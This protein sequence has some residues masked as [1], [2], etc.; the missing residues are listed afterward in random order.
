M[1]NA[2]RA[3]R[4][5]A[6]ATVDPVALFHQGRFEPALARIEEIRAAGAADAA[7]LNLAGACAHALGRLDQ[8]ELYWQTALTHDPAD[9]ALWNNLGILF[10]GQNRAAEAQS[11]YRR[12]LEL[13]PDG[14]DAHYNLGLLLQQAGEVEAAAGHYRRV[15]M[16]QP[17][18]ADAHNN[19]GALHRLRGQWQLAAACFAQAV[20]LRPGYA[21]AHSNLGLALA[22]LGR[23]A[24]GETAL[25]RALELQPGAVAAH[26]NLGL[27]LEA[28]KRP[29]E[30][31]HHFALSVAQD[32]PDAQA[33]LHSASQM[34]RLGR[35]D[36]AEAAYRSALELQPQRAD[37]H[38]NLAV[39]LAQR[40][41]DHAAE[42]GYRQAL[43]LAPDYAD[44]WHN[45]GLLY[46][47]QRRHA[48]A[49][50]A[51]LRFL[52]L[53]A[54]DPD[55][56]NSL[57]NVYQRMLRPQD[58]ERAY[59]RALA[60]RPGSAKTL[61]NLAALLQQECRSE[62]AEQ[63]YRAA[64]AADPEYPEARWNLGFLLLAQGRLAE[65]WPWMEARHDPRLAR[66]IATRPPL[67][68]AQWHGEP[69][70]GLAIV[71]WPEQGLGD[72]LQFVRYLPLLKAAGARRV[73]LV[74]Q[75]ALVALLRG[76]AGADQVVA[77][78]AAPG[79]LD[80]HDVW[81][82]MLSLPMHF[83]TT[84][85]TI[86]AHLPY[87]AP[88]VARL[89][90]WRSRLEAGLPHGARRV[91]LV[92]RGFS[93]HLNDT[94][95]S[96]PSLSILAP[97]WTVAGI[98]FVSLQRGM[99]GEAPAPVNDGMALLE[100]GSG[101]GDFG[102]TAAI[103]AQLDL[104]ICVD[105]AVAHLAGAMGK[106]CWVMLPAVHPDWRW[107]AQRRDCPWYPGVL[108]LYR[109]TCPERWDQVVTELAA[110]LASWAGT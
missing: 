110:D 43:S 25:R 75:D 104:V 97:L 47:R 48:Q 6:D 51:L 54:D 73:T 70:A 74:C 36:E 59:R 83:A 86:P 82:M 95:R 27:V 20:A 57:G 109:Q 39:L 79:Q 101:I 16:L 41:R 78:S 106:P 40:G 56:L 65:G 85:D 33:L 50:Q 71:V 105:T 98:S 21:Q 32:L 9:V 46:D 102:D 58:A 24:E 100:L 93:G 22:R 4:H 10:Q 49:E 89:A 11:A 63:T 64:I 14:A 96:L 55:G 77:L 72:Q 44:A 61:N 12:A 38:N 87:L 108:T 35:L 90:I 52:A 34:H 23:L 88:D 31:Q 3:P 19:L 53:R 42:C 26:A 62:A 69:L 5:T 29:S 107:M 1:E 84:L 7:L 18:H 99:D 13:H 37:T 92:W 30:A 66:P 68:F 2:D 103:V 60:S 45:L 8:A 28:R 81:V 67:P 17:A 80:S 15:L 91:G 76:V 94:H